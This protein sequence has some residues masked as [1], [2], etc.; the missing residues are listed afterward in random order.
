ME[1]V[2]SLRFPQAAAASHEPAEKKI[3]PEKAFGTY[4]EDGNVKGK[5]WLKNIHDKSAYP[6]YL[7][8]QPA[9]QV[10]GRG[11]SRDRDDYKA[12]GNPVLTATDKRGRYHVTLEK[13]TYIVDVYNA[14]GKSWKLIKGDILHITGSR[15]LHNCKIDN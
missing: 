11:R 4:Q 15:K 12:S 9:K 7:R 2:K 3:T 1:M 13:G 10:K 8:F 14:E 5:V 6:C